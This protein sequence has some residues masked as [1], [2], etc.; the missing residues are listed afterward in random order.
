MLRALSVPGIPE[1]G[2]QQWL[3]HVLIQT[4]CPTWEELR[5]RRWVRAMGSG[6][7]HA[8][9]ALFAEDVARYQEDGEYFD[10]RLLEVTNYAQKHWK[11]LFGDKAAYRD[12]DEEDIAPQLCEW[13]RMGGPADCVDSPHVQ[14]GSATA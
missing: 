3:Q 8:L 5:G 12:F 4:L 13:H 7:E 9:A 1:L 6:V 14:F 2:Y 11:R 10:D